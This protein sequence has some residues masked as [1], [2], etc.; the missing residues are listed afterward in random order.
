MPSAS[1]PKALLSLLALLGVT[2]APSITWAQDQC[3][4]AG[5]L[6]ADGQWAPRMAGV[7]L[8]GGQGQPIT[9]GSAE[10][11]AQ[12]KQVR[13]GR[14]AALSAC[15]DKQ[16]IAKGG[17][18]PSAKTPVP[19]VKAGKA[20]LDVTAVNTLPLEKAGGS[21]VELKLAAVPPER[22]MLKP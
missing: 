2:L 10:A 7:A 17:D 22:L 19:A 20:A 21:W 11:L 6:N 14:D 4:L 1:T 5:R 9:G 15:N 8:L 12:V 13:V 3:I 18:G 16:A